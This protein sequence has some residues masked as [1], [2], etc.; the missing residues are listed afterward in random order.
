VKAAEQF[1]SA[2]P[3]AFRVCFQTTLKKLREKGA[4]EGAN[5]GNYGDGQ[6]DGSK[7]KRKGNNGAGDEDDDEED[8][9]PKKKKARQ[10]KKKATIVKE[11]VVEESG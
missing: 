3:N 1:G 7:S 4:V 5:G 2:T 8:G 6:V 11:E 9:S 10:S